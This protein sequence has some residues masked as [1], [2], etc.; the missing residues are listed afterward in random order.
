MS[1]TSTTTLSSLAAGNRRRGVSQE[2]KSLYKEVISIRKESIKKDA[3]TMCLGSMKK[4]KLKVRGH[5]RR[6]APHHREA[7][8]SF[9]GTAE[10]RD[11]EQLIIA[12]VYKNEDPNWGRVGG[13][14]ERLEVS[15]EFPNINTKG[16]N[17][18][19]VGWG[20]GGGS[21]GGGHRSRVSPCRRPVTA[22]RDSR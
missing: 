2:E 6:P 12:A 4:W 8:T 5:R 16:S 14:S 19:T 11:F 1:K 13:G 20:G 17:S 7:L 18:R 3:G 15:E 21:G 22:G 9:I 10:Q